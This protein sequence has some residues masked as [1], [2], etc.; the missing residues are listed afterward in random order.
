MHRGPK[1]LPHLGWVCLQGLV[2]SVPPQFFHSF[3]GRADA[4]EVLE[5]PVLYLG[6]EESIIFLLL[7]FCISIFTEVE[8][9]SSL[10][11]TTPIN[12][13]VGLWVFPHL[14]GPNS[15]LGVAFTFLQSFLMTTVLFT[16]CLGVMGGVA[17]FH[18]RNFCG[19]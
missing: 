12:N 11:A 6:E 19:W 3:P 9:R 4:T 15:N 5:H 13:P 17:V 14:L 2:I 16:A 7:N 18:L 1:A 8:E 10:L